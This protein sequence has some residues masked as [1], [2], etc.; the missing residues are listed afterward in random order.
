DP[1]G[2]LGYID[3]MGER[4]TQSK[5]MGVDFDHVV[6]GSGSGGTLSGIVAGCLVHGLK[7]RVTAMSVAFSSEW[8]VE[9]VEEVFLGLRERYIPNLPSPAGVF[10]VNTGYIGGGYGKASPEL[11]RFIRYVA[12]SE[13]LLVDPTYS[14]KALFGLAEEIAKGTYKDEEKILFIHTGGAFGLFP[15]RKQFTE[16]S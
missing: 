4:K 10:S 14:G 5:E 6:F 8:A 12:S 15:Y 9:K 16:E 1:L 11:I 7:C 2:S 13:A 3:A